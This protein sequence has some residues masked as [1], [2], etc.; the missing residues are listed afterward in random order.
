ML[1]KK[2]EK[3]ETAWENLQNFE[4]NLKKD[5]K[6]ILV[7]E[8]IQDISEFTSYEMMNFRLYQEFNLILLFPNKIILSKN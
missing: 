6:K 3:I 4:D 7:Q 1:N 5:A 2:S 8:K